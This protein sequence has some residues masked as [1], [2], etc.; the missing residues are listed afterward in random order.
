MLLNKASTEP[1]KVASTPNEEPTPV[2]T[3]PLTALLPFLT[4]VDPGTTVVFPDEVVPVLVFGL[5]SLFGLDESPVETLGFL[6]FSLNTHFPTKLTSALSIFF[7][8]LS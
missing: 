8:S 1:A 3:L 6:V 2:L 7:S 5:S 4:V